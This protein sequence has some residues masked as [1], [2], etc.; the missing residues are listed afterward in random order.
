MEKIKG[1]FKRQW[2]EYVG[3]LIMWLVIGLVL[4]FGYKLWNLDLDVPMAYAGGDEMSI[5]VQAKMLE[6]Q[7]WVLSS[8]RLGAP[9]GTTF[10]DFTSNMMHNTET[11]IL[12]IFVMITGN[13]AA[14]VNLTFL[15]IFFMAGII[16]YF[17]LRQ[18]GITYWVASLASAVFGVSP[19]MF[20]RGAG[21]IVLAEAYFVPLSLLLCFWIFE[22]DDVL[23][24][25]KNFFKVK[26]NYIAIIAIILIAN[27]GIAYYP[28][29]TCFMLVVTAISKFLKDKHFKD[30]LRAFT[31]IVGIC[32][33][34]VLSIL[35]GFIYSAINGKNIDAVVRTGFAETELYGLK[36][37][38][39]FIP[40]NSHK[41]KFLENMISEY[42]DNSPLINENIT[43]YIG[44]VGILGFIILMFVLFIRRDTIVKKRLAFLSELN[45]MLV[46]LGTLGGFGTM[47][48]FL[49]SP[50]L[51]A[52]TRISIF[53]E[54]VCIV[55]FAV[56][57]YYLYKKYL[58]SSKDKVKRYTVMAV[59]AVIMIGA[60]FE[61]FP[62][63]YDPDYNVIYATYHYDSEFIA[64]I[65]SMVEEG[66]MIYQL[67]YHKYPEGEAVNEMGD[68]QLFVG[69][70]HSEKLRWSYGSVKGREGD[71]WNKSVSKMSY[72]KMVSTLKEAGFA[73]IYIDRT[74]YE[75]DTWETMEKK[76]SEIIGN[77][78]I[79]SENSSL[80][81]IKF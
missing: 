19:Y 22:R 10:Y 21:H 70:L 77:E 46:L 65:E 4:I 12:K 68:Y 17:V 53:I 40:A 79:V 37:I 31:A 60:S 66:A 33:F 13:A 2:K 26:K 71:E 73:G 28:F 35:P 61:N 67:P 52:Y 1:H 6:S 3:V 18:L 24:I 25:D 49:I 30:V 32:I 16:S 80:S 78:P 42:Y 7:S 54:Y 57:I 8:D 20:M 63:G 62:E 76:L 56:V 41:I 50:L 59:G 11:V 15:S 72:K 9:Y 48:A 75:E 43:S 29:F 5:L 47:F 51:R 69:F 27:N 34:V 23:R 64:Q 74:A 58:K 38:Q 14:G 55:A 36:I 39:L 81:F 45:L 44:I